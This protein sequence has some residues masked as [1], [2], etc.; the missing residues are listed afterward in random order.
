METSGEEAG[1]TERTHIISI[2]QIDD[3]RRNIE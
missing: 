3:K 1:E 2:L